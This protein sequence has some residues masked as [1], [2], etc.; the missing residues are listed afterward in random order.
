MSKICEVCE[1]PT[2]DYDWAINPMGLDKK[3]LVP[4]CVPCI[5]IYNTNVILSGD[6]DEPD[7]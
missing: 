3:D 1:E 7:A 5:A 6:L 4:V 2:D